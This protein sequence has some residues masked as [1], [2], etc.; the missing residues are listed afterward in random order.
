MAEFAM[1]ELNHKLSETWLL[2]QRIV[3]DIEK[4]SPV[5][6]ILLRQRLTPKNKEDSFLLARIRAVCEYQLVTCPSMTQ[7]RILN[8]KDFL[9]GNISVVDLIRTRL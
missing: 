1:A 4:L 2:P 8:S 5:E 6:T 9:S 7:F 3:S